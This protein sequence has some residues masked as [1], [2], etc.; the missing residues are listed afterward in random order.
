MYFIET[1]NSDTYLYHFAYIVC[2]FYMIYSL[3]GTKSTLD[4]VHHLTKLLWMKILLYNCLQSLQ[5]CNNGFLL[6]E[7]KCRNK[8][9]LLWNLKWTTGIFL[10]RRTS[11]WIILTVNWG[12]LGWAVAN[13]YNQP[14]RPVYLACNNQTA[15]IRRDDTFARAVHTSGRYMI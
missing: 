12:N 14:V 11:I 1:P 5:Q 13:L 4:N 2:M 6:R 10:I 9:L 15:Y 3:Y 7:P 8:I